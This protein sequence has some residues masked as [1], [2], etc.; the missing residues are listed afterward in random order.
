[1]ACLFSRLQLRK[2]TVNI[3]LAVIGVLSQRYRWMRGT[4]QVVSIYMKKL[5]AVAKI[6]RPLLPWVM[7]ACYTADIWLI[8]LVNFL[9]LGM[10]RIPC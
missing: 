8:P 4:W 2:R 1:M 3:F 7:G 6:R 10:V 5:H 9:F